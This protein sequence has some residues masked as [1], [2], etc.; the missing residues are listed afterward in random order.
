MSGSGP[1]E[2]AFSAYMGKISRG[3]KKIKM[4]YPEIPDSWNVFQR[5]EFID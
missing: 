5:N 4:N 3:A 2:G 1:I